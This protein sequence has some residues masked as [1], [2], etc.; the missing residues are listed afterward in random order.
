MPEIISLLGFKLHS[1]KGKR[2]FL[3]TALNQEL[4]SLVPAYCAG[5]GESS[6]LANLPSGPQ[7]RLNR[8][9]V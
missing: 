4:F 3:V 2:A 6:G 9:L 7:T 8:W 5:L 1:A